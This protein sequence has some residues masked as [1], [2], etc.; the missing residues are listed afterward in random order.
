MLTVTDWWSFLHRDA[1]D[2]G[3]SNAVLEAYDRCTAVRR[4]FHSGLATQDERDLADAEYSYLVLLSDH[5]HQGS[6]QRAFYSLS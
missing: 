1:L 2:R 5:V 3:L 6:I 4:A